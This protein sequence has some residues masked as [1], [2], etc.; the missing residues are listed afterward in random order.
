MALV[1]TG[2][3]STLTVD[4]TSGITFP[5]STLQASAGQI[6]QV[7]NVM[8]TDTFT[9]TTAGSWAGANY[10][11]ATG[12]VNVV[13]T[14]GATFYL[15]GVQLEVGS[16]ATGFEYLDYGTELIMCQRYYELV[17]KLDLQGYVQANKQAYINTSFVPKRTSPTIASASTSNADNTTNFGSNVTLSNT[18]NQHMVIQLIGNNGGLNYCRLTCNNFSYSAEL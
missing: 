13:A 7:V 1:L 8:K 16:S 15:T 6:L 9:S 3:S 2:N 17:S 5:N 18:D 10:V 12:Q 4:S 11:G 14:N